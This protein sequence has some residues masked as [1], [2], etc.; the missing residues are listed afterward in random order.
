MMLTEGSVP[1][2]HIR[3]PQI[4][5]HMS[6]DK[7]MWCLM[8]RGIQRGRLTCPVGDLVTSDTGEGVWPC[9]GTCQRF[10]PWVVWGC[11]GVIAAYRSES[12]Q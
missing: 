11:P 12:L 8:T 2:N 3:P 5:S 10:H 7:V 1:F 4:W 6:W 9:A